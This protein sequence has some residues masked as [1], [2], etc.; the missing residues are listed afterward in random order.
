MNDSDHLKDRAA[1]HAEGVLEA[2]WIKPGRRLPMVDARRVETVAGQ[3]I[4]GNANQGT[5]RQVT[6]LSA[7]RW[8]RATSKFGSQIDPRLRRA[9][10]LVSGVELENSRGMILRI[11]TCRIEIHGETRPCRRMDEALLGLEE[12]LDIHWGGGAYG[13]VLD[14]S[15][16]QI[17]DPVWLGPVTGD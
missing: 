1:N 16:I 10:L 3:G 13:I 8:R 2:I 12:A 5:K 4:T 11:G 14:S 17:G 7:E 15:F 9:N 6:I